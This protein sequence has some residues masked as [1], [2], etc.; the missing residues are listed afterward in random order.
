MRS[1]LP[2]AEPWG[3]RSAG[4][5]L[6]GRRRLAQVLLP[7]PS[8]SCPVKAP[9]FRAGG[10]LL[11]LCA[12]CAPHSAPP[13]AAPNPRLHLTLETTPRPPTSLDPTTFTVQVTDAAGKPVSGATATAWLF[14]PGM[15]MGDDTVT[16][17]EKANGTYAGTGRFTMAGAWRV[18]VS[19]SKGADHATQSFDLTTK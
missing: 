10:L 6:R 4:P 8:G 9:P 16:L 19:V 12:G 5:R 7:L 17:R 15:D 1:N 18:T 2:Q 14:M 13:S 11:L 3:F